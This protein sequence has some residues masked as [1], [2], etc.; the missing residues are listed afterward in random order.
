MSTAALWITLAVLLLAPI[1]IGLI[2]LWDQKS[3]K[4]PK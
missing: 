1:I 3:P 4:V 2:F